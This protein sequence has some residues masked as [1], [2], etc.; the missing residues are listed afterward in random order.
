[1]LR[2][3]AIIILV[4]ALAT[5]IW[6]GLTAYF[7]EYSQSAAWVRGLYARKEQAAR[8]IPGPKLV[9]IGGSGTHYGFSAAYL[10]RLTGLP[11]VNFGTHAG[12]GPRYILFRARR[13]LRRGDIA[14]LAIETPINNAV[15]PSE[16]TAEQVISDDLPYLLH[17]RPDRSLRIL[18]GLDPRYALRRAANMMLP[19][20]PHPT[21]RA[22]SVTDT[23]DEALEVSKLV[24]PEGSGL[25]K[26]PPPFQMVGLV[27][28]PES[29]G[30][31]FAW[32]KAHEVKI[33]LLWTPMLADK[34][35]EGAFYRRQFALVEQWY[36][37]VGAISLG[38][39]S[40]YYLGESEV[41]DTIFH[42]NE[43]GRQRM[44]EIL[45]AKLCAAIACPT[46]PAAKR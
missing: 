45:A 26:N 41:F 15:V 35:Y 1:M 28:M 24:G 37:T 7:S 4:M 14:V 10:T 27:E 22:D 5:V 38:S 19:W 21:R 8:R 11:A 6:S 30:E 32:A 23:G 36:R 44:T 9:L 43:R 17:E 39:V 29:L 20:N 42:A 3:L 18:F 12:L 25:P 16:N 2:S 40:D 46:P 13:A 33:A 34:A 31:F